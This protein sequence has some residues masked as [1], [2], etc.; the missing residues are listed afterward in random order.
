MASDVTIHNTSQIKQPTNDGISHSSLKNI[1]KMA[2]IIKANA[3]KVMIASF[4]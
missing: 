3:I 1:H 4:N 2:A